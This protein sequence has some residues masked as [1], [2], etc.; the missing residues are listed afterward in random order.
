MR[1]L[2]RPP[3]SGLGIRP[4]CAV[5]PH[6]GVRAGVDRWWRWRERTNRTAGGVGPRPCSATARVDPSRSVFVVVID[7][8]DGRDVPSDQRHVDNVS[9]GLAPASHRGSRR[10]LGRSGTGGGYCR[11]RALSCSRRVAPRDQVGTG[12]RRRH[13]GGKSDPV[14]E[15]EPRTSCPAFTRGRIAKQ[16]GSGR[17]RPY[18]W[19]TP[20]PPTRADLPTE[21]ERR[22]SDYPPTAPCVSTYSA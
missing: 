17:R 12:D 7:A 22:F 3:M 16:A 2:A 19:P 14:S 1:W 13:D 21:R 20:P 6:S 5:P 8:L 9:P 11:R 18:V 15:V 10:A 4:R